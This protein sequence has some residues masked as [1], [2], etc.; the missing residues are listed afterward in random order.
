MKTVESSSG[1]SGRK[2]P[3]SLRHGE[4]AGQHGHQ[5]DDREDEEDQPGDPE[6]ALLGGLEGG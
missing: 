5:D 2:P 3:S 4:P 1:D 6:S